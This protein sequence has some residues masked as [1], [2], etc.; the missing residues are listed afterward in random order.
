MGGRKD[1]HRLSNVVW[2]D[3]ILNGEIE[4]N[5]VLQAEALRRGI[6]IS[7]HADPT[8]IPVIHAVHGEVWL[9]DDGR[10][11]PTDQEPPF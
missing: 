3:S 1:K 8:L 7:I 10:A 4:S 9:T 11:V 6:K 5:P 2:L